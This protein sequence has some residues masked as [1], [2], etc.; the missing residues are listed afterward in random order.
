MLSFSDLTLVYD[1]TTGLWHERESRGFNR[2]RV[3]CYQYAWA[4]HIVGDYSNGKLYDLD[5]GHYTEDDEEIAREAVSPPLYNKGTRA[6]MHE[7]CVGFE[8][9]MGLNSGQGDDPIA[10]IS[11]S[12]DNGHTWSNEREAS[13][14]QIGEYRNKAL[15]TRL[16]MFRQRQ[17]Q[18]P[19]PWRR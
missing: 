10:L 9:G 12:D 18:R 1:I 5:L 19:M 6:I 13:I 2:W 16:G 15:V 11:W 7:F 14:G 8:P 3:S 17:S 4:K